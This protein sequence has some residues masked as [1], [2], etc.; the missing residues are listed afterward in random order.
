[1]WEELGVVCN[2]W[3]GPWLMGGDFNVIKFVHKKSPRGVMNR[4]MR[5]FNEFIHSQTLRDNRMTN[6]NFHLDK[7]SG[8]PWLMP[9]GQIFGIKLLGRFVSPICSEAISKLV[10]DHWLVPLSTS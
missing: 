3:V 10:L 9:S 2:A 5:E 8:S 1:M 7:W 4:S 6:A